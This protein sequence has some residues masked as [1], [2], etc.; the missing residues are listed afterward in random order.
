MDDKIAKR[1]VSI[2]T[3]AEALGVHRST[4]SR[5]LSDRSDHRIP[6]ETVERIRQMA[7]QMNWAPNPWA[8]SLTTHRTMT[9]GLLI[10]RLSDVV[11][12]TIFEAAEVEAR[13]FGYYTLTVSSQ[14]DPDETLRLASALVDRRIDGVM[15]ATSNIVDE[16]PAFLASEKIPFILINRS[17]SDYLC[18]RGDDEL[19]G[20]M[21]VEHLLDE[22]HRRIGMISGPMTV[23]TA[24]Y[25]RQGYLRALESRGVPADERYIVG[26]SFQAKDGYLAARELLRMH[27]SPTA[28]F[29]VND[30]VAIGA[31]SAAREAG[32]RVPED[33]AVVG[34]NDSA[35]ASLLP[36][37]LSSV[38][39]PLSLMGKKGVEMLISM[40]DGTTPPPQEDVLFTP[41]LI[42]RQS[43]D[44]RVA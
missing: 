34:Y 14:D 42:V 10:P 22:G 16:T 19:G 35:V 39:M 32:V 27:H 17:N 33:L 20:H 1:A 41:E 25:R 8:R 40:V 28:I 12:A 38:R 2:D 9:L 11:L 43:S 3:I 44:L 29:A 13:K 4:V 31:M 5:A 6:A 23:S 26:S 37:P 15:L 30:S 7:V 18:V 21:A 36:T 24:I